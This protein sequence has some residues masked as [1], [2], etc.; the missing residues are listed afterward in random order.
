MIRAVNEGLGGFKDAR[1]LNR[2]K[3]FVR[4]FSDRIKNYGKLQIFGEAASMAN[5]PVIETIAVC[6]LL[7]ITLLLYW[8]GRPVESVIP[9]LTSIW[10]GN[11]AT[12]ADHPGNDEILYQ[13]AVL[14]FLNRADLQRYYGARS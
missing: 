11:D 6:G 9:I 1:V 13:S 5:K 2:E 12:D 8:Q 4:R 3:W 10:G 7:L 14:R